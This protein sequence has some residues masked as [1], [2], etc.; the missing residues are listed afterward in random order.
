MKVIVLGGAGFLGSHVVDALVARG[1]AVT[2]VDDYSSCWMDEENLVNG[3]FE[4]PAADY[5][6]EHDSVIAGAEALVVCSMRYPL[7]RDRC[8]Y[9]QAFDGYVRTPM[10][11]IGRSMVLSK[12]VLKRVVVASTI[13]MRVQRSVHRADPDVHLA[14]SLRNALLYWHRPPSFCTYFVHLPEL[15]GERRLPEAG[16]PGEGALPVEV[17]A[18]KMMELATGRCRKL[19][20]VW[21]EEL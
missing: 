19:P 1:D 10:R 16:D 20:D 14:W 9:F 5:V 13:R 8:A 12:N 7:E 17:A 15:S 21:P 6:A 11:M 2:V 3:K 4:N 18:A